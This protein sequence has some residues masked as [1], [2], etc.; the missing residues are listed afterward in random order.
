MSY[1]NTFDT[2]QE[3]QDTNQKDTEETLKKV[4]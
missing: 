2:L 1:V 4:M 3:K